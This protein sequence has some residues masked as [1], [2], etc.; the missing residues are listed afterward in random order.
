M[1]QTGRL[2]QRMHSPPALET[3]KSPVDLVPRE[4]MLP[5]LQ[6]AASVLCPTHTSMRGKSF[7]VF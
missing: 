3:A 4:D 2:K 6:T 7:I 5:G 1:P